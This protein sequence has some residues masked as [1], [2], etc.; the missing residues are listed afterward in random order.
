MAVMPW[1]SVDTTPGVRCWKLHSILLLLNWQQC[2]LLMSGKQKGCCSPWTQRMCNF[3]KIL[4]FNLSHISYKFS[5]SSS[6][7][8]GFSTR[9]S[10]WTWC[11]IVVVLWRIES[12]PA[13]TTCVEKIYHSIHI[14]S[15][16]QSLLAERSQYSWSTGILVLQMEILGKMSPW[17][18][19]CRTV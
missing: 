14:Q 8:E 6:T 19:V 4:T 3:P 11:W 18:S 2:A 10:L 1:C 15:V 5:F 17:Y 13:S 12:L 9:F 7:A 16:L